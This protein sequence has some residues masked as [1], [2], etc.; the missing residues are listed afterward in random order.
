MEWFNV[1]NKGIPC[2]RGMGFTLDI[3]GDN[4][5]IDNKKYI[6]AV[7]EELYELNNM[8]DKE[9]DNSVIIRKGLFS[10]TMD[11]NLV[12]YLTFSPQVFIIS[13]LSNL[14][15]KTTIEEEMVESKLIEKA[16]KRLHTLRNMK[17]SAQLEKEFPTLY[18]T[19]KLLEDKYN[20][21]NEMR[22]RYVIGKKMGLVNEDAFE[23]NMAKY[24]KMFAAYGLN[25]SNVNVKTF[26]ENMY[27]KYMS[28]LKPETYNK[29]TQIIARSAIDLSKFDDC[30]DKEKFE[31]LV[32]ASCLTNSYLNPEDAI[33]NFS[34]LTQYFREHENDMDSD[35]SIMMFFNGDNKIF[36]RQELYRLYKE[37]LINHPEVKIVRKNIDDFKG[38]SYDDIKAYLEQFSGELEVSW[39]ILP[40][41]ESLFDRTR[42][43]SGSSMT[44]SEKK[45]K[46]S[47][48]ERILQ[49]KEDFFN[50]N[51]PYLLLKGKNSFLG[52]IGY[53]YPNAYVVLE[54]FFKNKTGTSIAEDAIY[55][56]KV[57]EFLDLSIKSK[58]EIIENHLCQR[59]THHRGWQGKVEDILKKAVTEDSIE[60]V[61]IFEN[62]IRHL[63]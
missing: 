34:Y 53:I 60:R 4:C 40:S 28:L 45:E 42:Y 7:T 57:E 1:F 37:Y 22:K 55:I 38:K 21:M 43:Q 17:Y 16:R 39:D 24:R 63:K 27:K 32:A 18:E 25:T 48:K 51:K 10:L 12:Q 46:E 50:K 5:S 13:L 26:I 44:E 41:G 15:V 9:V 29:I 3:V 20:E 47:N 33:S 49:E 14:D 2:D 11:E 61:Q 58:P 30:L 54:K 8:I 52:Y 23:S 62:Q 6:K 35:V 19:Y 36:T 59:V 31:L 56:M